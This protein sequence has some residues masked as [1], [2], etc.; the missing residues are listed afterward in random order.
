[1]GS[2]KQLQ[3]NYAKAARES[4]PLSDREYFSLV[5]SE[6]LANLPVVASASVIMSYNAF[7]AEL[8]LAFFHKEMLCAGKTLAFPVTYGQGCMAAYVPRGG[9]EWKTDAFGIRTPVPESSVLIEPE[10][11]DL[12]VVPCVAFD[13]YKMRIGWGGGYYD[14][15][16]P[17]CINAYKIGVAFEVQCIEK[18]ALA[19][20]WDIAL[21]S[22]MTESSFY[23]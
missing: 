4:L 22:V 12:V 6:K 1:M 21:D 20:A 9:E 7:N 2:S 23:E 15:Y 19:P 18:I 11:I 16:L 10:N 17:L 3:R 8:D 14:R 13:P 5:V